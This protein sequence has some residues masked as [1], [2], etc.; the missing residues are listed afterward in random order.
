MSDEAGKF[1]PLT[2]VQADFTGIAVNGLTKFYF[3]TKATVRMLGGLA[4]ALAL[5]IFWAMASNSAWF[6]ESTYNGKTV[7]AGPFCLLGMNATAYTANRALYDAG[8]SMDCTYIGKITDGW[9]M[10][11]LMALGVWFLLGSLYQRYA[12]NTTAFSLMGGEFG[13]G[14][15]F[16]NRFL[17]YVLTIL[18]IVFTVFWV[19]FAMVIFFR[20][21]AWIND[22]ARLMDTIG[23]D[24]DGLPLTTDI[25][26]VVSGI[27]LFYAVTVWVYLF[28]WIVPVVMHIVALIAY[29]WVYKTTGQDDAFMYIYILEGSALAGR[30]KSVQD[31]TAHNAHTRAGTGR[32]GYTRGGGEA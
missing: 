25:W 12:S 1:S 27:Y 21:K 29:F 32:G 20:P 15:M 13:K 31:A 4:V 18:V 17:E 6:G 3:W 24:N 10:L 16:F 22:G 30:S 5:F 11:G 26:S 9:A 8:A 2:D 23:S 19:I 14:M 28:A 7:S